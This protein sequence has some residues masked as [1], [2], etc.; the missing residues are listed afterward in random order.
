MGASLVEAAASSTISRST[1]A[2]FSAKPAAPERPSLQLGSVPSETS[3]QNRR[4]PEGA[5]GALMATTVALSAASFYSGDSTP[6]MLVDRGSTHNC[7]DPLLTPRLQDM[8]S[9]YCVLD[10]PHTIV[11]TG[12]HVFQ[13]VA[14]GTV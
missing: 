2:H 12:Q 10:V 6:T 9:D 7:V 11:A 3:Q 4:M 14:T 5:F 1:P 13:G 8:M